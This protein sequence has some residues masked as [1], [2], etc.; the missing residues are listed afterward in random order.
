MSMRQEKKLRLSQSYNAKTL[1]EHSGRKRFIT[2]ALKDVE[3]V[4]VA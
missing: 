2:Y 4:E 1:R 3:K